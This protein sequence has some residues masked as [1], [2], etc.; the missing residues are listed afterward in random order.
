MS[1]NLSYLAHIF[2][3]LGYCAELIG[4]LDKRVCNSQR[5]HFH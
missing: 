1:D 3:F 2:A 5:M 4:S